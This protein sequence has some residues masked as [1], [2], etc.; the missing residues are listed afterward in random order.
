MKTRSRR[1]LPILIGV[2]LVLAAWATSV[3]ALTFLQP[4]GQP[5]AVVAR[6][7]MK[8]ALATVIAANGYVLQVRGDTIIAIS[9]E[10]GFV[11]RLYRNGALFVVL[12]RTGGCI[13][14]SGERA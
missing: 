1:I 8:E 2:P 13:V 14:A 11:P 3:E 9:D 7:G 12:A 6:G 10:E 4:P 5:V